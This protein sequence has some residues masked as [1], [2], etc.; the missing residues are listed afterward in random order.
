MC[1]VPP[2]LHHSGGGRYGDSKR[3][4]LQMQ[5]PTVCLMKMNSS[6]DSCSAIRASAFEK[7][8]AHA[9]K[10]GMI[11]HATP[12]CRNQREPHGVPGNLIF[13]LL[14]YSPGSGVRVSLSVSTYSAVYVFPSGSV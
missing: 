12:F 14:E 1:R 3:T 7:R 13:A 10:S 8:H 9:S 2:S 6:I 4:M 5:S 11:R